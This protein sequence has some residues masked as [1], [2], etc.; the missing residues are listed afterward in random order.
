MKPDVNNGGQTDTYQWEQTKQEVTINVPI[1]E[2]TT[3]RQLTVDIQKAHLKVG[4]KGQP[5]IIDGEL[6]SE[7]KRGDSI[8]CLES[9]DAGK[10][11]LQISLTKRAECWWACAIKGDQQIKANKLAEKIDSAADMQ[12]MD[13]ETRQFVEQMMH[14]TRQEMKGEAVGDRALEGISEL[15]VP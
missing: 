5:L 8:W 13:P 6:C 7:V 1:P 2:N 11:V 9:D 12:K 15:Q 3:T 14:K 10:R 4:L